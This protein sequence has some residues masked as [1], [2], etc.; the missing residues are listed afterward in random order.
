MIASLRETIAALPE[1]AVGSFN[2]LDLD[3]AAA[4]IE[5]AEGASTPAVIG[6]AARHFEQVRGDARAAAYRRLMEQATV[7]LALHLDHAMPDDRDLV[8]RALDA[9]FTS[10]MV[11]GSRLPLEANIELTRWAVETARPYAASVEAELGAVA[12]EEGVADTGADA[13]EEFS[14]TEP[15]E[16][17]TFI[18]ATGVDALAIAVG[19]AHGIYA[20]APRVSVETIEAIRE[21]TDVPL[22][23]HGAT[24]VPDAVI[25]DCVRAGIRKINFFSALLRTAMDMVRANSGRQDNDYLAFKEALAEAWRVEIEAQIRIYSGRG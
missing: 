17:V 8:R 19:T 11:D 4:V 23:L 7:P 20:Q 24:G 1:G 16:A 21:R 5:A 15:D 13:P 6:I 22:V 2:T 25:R 10:I 14:Y 9:G 12:G 3:M 18:Q